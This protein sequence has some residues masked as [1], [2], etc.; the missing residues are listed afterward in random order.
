MYMHKQT[1]TSDCTLFAIVAV[2]CLLLDGDP[3]TV[4]QKK[5]CLHF[6]RI[7]ETNVIALFP[8]LKTPQP[9]ERTSRV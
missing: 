5:L 6:I 4:D 7:L 8:T 2:T 9:V 1:G 3:T